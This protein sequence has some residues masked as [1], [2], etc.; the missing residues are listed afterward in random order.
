[1]DQR[2]LA[3]WLLALL[4]NGRSGEAYNVGSDEPISISALAHRVR[5]LISPGKTVRIQSRATGSIERNRYIPSIKKAKLELG[6]DLHF[7]LEQGVISTAQ[8]ANRM[9]K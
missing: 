1:M 6:L 9:M 4:A 5:D 2:D 3:E 7:T 8:A